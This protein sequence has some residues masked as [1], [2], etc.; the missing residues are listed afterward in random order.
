MAFKD[1]LK[2]KVP[3]YLQETP[4]FPIIMKMISDAKITG[5]ESLRHWLNV[6]IQKCRNDLKEFSKAGPTMNRKRV[7]CAERMDILKLVQDKILQYVK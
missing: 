6:E 3:A 4:E 2:E 7:R 5:P 1:V